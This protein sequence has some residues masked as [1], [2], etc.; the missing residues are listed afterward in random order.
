MNRVLFFLGIA[1]GSLFAQSNRP[2]QISLDLSDAPRKIL[3]AELHIPVA[4]GPATLVFPGWI[5]G[6]HG[7]TGPIDNLSGI[8]FIANGQTLSWRRDDVNMY[9]FHLEVPAGVSD[10][11]AKVDFLATA[12][13]TGFSAGA[14]TNANLAIVS[15]NEFVLY[16]S[17]SAAA[18]L[19]IEPSIRFPE[20]WKF[21][22][23]LREVS[24]DGNSVRFRAVPLNM[25]VDSPVLAGRFFKEIPLAPEITPKHFL[26]MAADGPE[27]L[28]PSAEQLAAFSNLVRETGALYKSRHYESYHFLLTLSDSVAH[29]GLEHHES[30]DDRVEA[31]TFLDEDLALV[32][33]D[34]LPH[35]FTHSWNGKYRR[36]AGLVTAN[37]QQPMKGD[38]LWVYEGLTQYLGDVL[39]AR[40]GIWTPEEYRAYLADSAASLDHRPGRTWRDLEDTAI[41]AQILSG[42]TDQ[43]DNWR[44]SVDYYPEGELIWLEV[45]TIIRKT[46]AGRKSLNDFC[47]RFFG[48]GGNTP[49]EVIPYTFQDLVTEL[50]AVQPYDWADFLREKVTTKAP[51]AP[52][53]GITAAGYRIEYTD[54]PNEYTRATDAHERAVNA[55]YSIGLRV[56]DGVI[57]DVLIGSPAYRAGLGP[58]MKIIAVNGRQMNEDVFRQAIKDTAGTAHNLELI[59]ENTGYYKFVRIEYHGGE[60]Y[61]HLVREPNTPALLDDILKPLLKH[62]EVKT[63]E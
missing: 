44:R 12:A 59:V 16:P 23:A 46:S 52:L 35:E 38:L 9:M 50:N 31:R 51:H 56:A 36:P 15:W 43:W 34:L 33:G 21:G 4:P 26:D 7:P 10:L 40:S 3:R 58:G 24:R 20:E 22:T 62:P 41:S 18:Q 42:T 45:D 17:G 53:G 28:N 2:I 1:A 29:F 5:P 13:P 39:A 60:K 32:E 27:D 48:L 57:S 25:L 49:P 6:E 11:E 37:Y 47:A 54:R 8:T 30:S 63:A 14:S 55:W 61:P 19:E